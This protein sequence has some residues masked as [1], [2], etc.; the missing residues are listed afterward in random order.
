METRAWRLRLRAPLHVG[1]RGIGLEETLDYV[2]SDTLFSA[3]VVAWTQLEA[4]ADVADTLAEAFAG[5]PPLRITSAMPFVD[6]V[7]L[8]PKPMLG[9]APALEKGESGKP[10][11]RVKWISAD[12]FA[13]LCSN[14]S[15]ATLD[16][17]WRTARLLQGGEVWIG[18]SEWQASNTLP[19]L[20]RDKATL[21]DSK[22]VAKV[23]VDRA[24]NA[25][26]LF[27][28]GR[29]HFAQE[30]GLWF[31]ASG[32]PTWLRRLED[33]LLLLADAGLGGQRSRGN[34]QFTLDACDPPALITAAETS[35][36]VLLSRCAPRAVE[37][38]LLR[39]EH[40]AYRL[41]TVGGFNGTPTDPPRVR[42]QVRMLAEGSV[43]GMKDS[44]P[45]YLV[46]V[47]PDEKSGLAHRIFRYGF[48]FTAP[49]AF[50]D[51]GD[52]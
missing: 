13:Q 49:I 24:A 34:G 43:I 10:F 30:A 26:A 6:D 39:A 32:D 28:V 42:K 5:E 33:A 46:D 23:T 45:G 29:V 40:A 37:I 19:H 48:G 31:A 12:V 44:T 17:L 1:E 21:W 18:D 52:A 38:P 8:L 3:L 2:P 11:K 14:A 20:A 22:R 35:H 50:A 41:E 4:H 36:G 15:Q 16:G 7:L 9:M 47:T 27:H 51:G 25:S